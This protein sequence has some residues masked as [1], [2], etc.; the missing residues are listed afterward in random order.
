M[1]E[2]RA[3]VT[4]VVDG[5]TID[6]VTDLGFGMDGLV[7]RL[8]LLGVDTP[9]RADYEQWLSA[10]DFTQ[11][12]CA[13]HVDAKGWLVITT[14]K[15]THDRDKADSFGRYLAVVWSMDKTANLNEELIAKGFVYG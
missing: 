11:S 8:R 1:W 4:N 14:I 2:Y 13:A 7:M 5:D 10:K 9:E 3:H 12:W 6:V 15:N